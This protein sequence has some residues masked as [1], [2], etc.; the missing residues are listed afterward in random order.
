[1]DTRLGCSTIGG[2]LPGLTGSAKEGVI[3][4]MGAWP[5]ESEGEQEW[6]SREAVG[7]YRKDKYFSSSLICIRAKRVR[8]FIASSGALKSSTSRPRPISQHV[9]WGKILIQLHGL[10]R[11]TIAGPSATDRFHPAALP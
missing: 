2:N 1:M 11:T 9:C 7:Q 3:R 10:D 5:G 6:D 4:A 8:S